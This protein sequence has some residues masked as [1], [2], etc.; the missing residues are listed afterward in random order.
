LV[1]VHAGGDDS[2]RSV[3]IK[4]G[5]MGAG[6]VDAVAAAEYVQKTVKGK[7]AIHDDWAPSLNSERSRRGLPGEPEDNLQT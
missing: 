2:A 3:L 4:T 7:A 5:L 1:K 6:F